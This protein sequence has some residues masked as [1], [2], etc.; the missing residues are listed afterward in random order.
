VAAGV[1]LIAGV[2]WIGLW[3]KESDNKKMREIANLPQEL[4]DMKQVSLVNRSPSDRLKVV[5]QDFDPVKDRQVI[6]VLIATINDDPNVN[7]RLAACGALY[8]FKNDDKAKKGFIQ[9]LQKQTDPMV[10]IFLIEILSEI[11]EKESF[12]VINR[13]Y[14]KGNLLPAVR[15]K[16]EEGLTKL[17]EV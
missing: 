9:S 8:Q 17:R 7:V 13:L 5:S 12:E 6:D 4:Q 11:K 2:F 1:I 16:A 15:K 14:N 10:Q 3:F